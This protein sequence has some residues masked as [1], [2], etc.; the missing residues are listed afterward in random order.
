MRAP[1]ARFPLPPPLGWW[2]SDEGVCLVLPTAGSP[3]QSVHDRKHGGGAVGKARPWDDGHARCATV[4]EVGRW[5][6]KEDPR[7]AEWRRGVKY[8]ILLSLSVTRGDVTARLL[9]GP[10]SNPRPSCS[11]KRAWE[12]SSLDPPLARL[13]CQAQAKPR[14]APSASRVLKAICLLFIFAK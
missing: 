13:G 8:S 5:M 1:W 4:V 2:R 14:G 3:A 9:P 12:G 6:V 11:E 10:L 7:T